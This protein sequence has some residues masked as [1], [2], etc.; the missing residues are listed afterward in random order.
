[1]CHAVL[2]VRQDF[3]EL[4]KL[5]DVLNVPRERTRM[6]QDKVHASHVP[7]EHLPVKAEVSQLANAFR[8]VDTELTVLQDLSHVW[9]VRETLSVV[10]LPSTVSRNV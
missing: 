8:F 4:K 1:M 5:I 10:F 9:N 6:N 3:M 7:K 2:N